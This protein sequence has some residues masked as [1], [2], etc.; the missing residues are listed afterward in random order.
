MK[1][2]LAILIITVTI[3]AQSAYNDREI[4]LAVSSFSGDTTRFTNRF[5]AGDCEGLSFAVLAPYGEDSAQFV[6]GY[7][8]GCM[9]NGAV[10]WKRPWTVI[11]TFDASGTY[12]SSTDNVDNAGNDSDAVALLDSAQLSPTWTMLMR[13]FTPW[14]SQYARFVVQGL[15]TNSVEPYN[16][17][18]IIHQPK[19][20]RSDGGRQPEE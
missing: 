10:R 11:D 5:A 16:V 15:S 18:L 6:I 3:S 20:I 17:F 14:R 19:Y 9:V 13:T 1:S 7:Q 8:R 4:N 12:A 2:I